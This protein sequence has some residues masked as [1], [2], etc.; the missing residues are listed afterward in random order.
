ME[1]RNGSFDMIKQAGIERIALIDIGSN[2][3]RLVIFNVDSNSYYSVSEIQNIKVSARLVQYVEDGR[4]SEKGINILT[5]LVDKYL[6]IISQY[7]VDRLIAVATA[8]VRNSKNVE[9]II[10]HVYDQ[11]GLE[12]RVL[13][14]EE[15][16]FYGNYAVRY[17]FN[18]YDGISVDIGGGST[19]VT[20]FKGKKIINSH[21]F[22]FGAVSLT[23]EFFSGKKHSDPTAIKETTKWVKKQFQK[24]DWL[25]R[26]NV[27]IV[28]IGGSARN[29][30]E[31]YQLQTDYPIAGTH[32]Y[33]MEPV[34]VEETLELF[35][36]KDYEDLD[37]LDGLSQDRKD[38]I[39]P[40][41][42]VFQQLLAVANSPKFILSRRGLR[43]GIVIHHLNEEHNDPYD[44]YAVPQQ[45][46]IRLTAQYN[47]QERST[48][49]RITIADMLLVQLEENNILKP[50]IEHLEL[51]YYGATLYNL[52]S[53]IEN[54][55]SSQHTYYVISNTN[56]HGFDHYDRVRLALLASYK[57]RSLYQQ[58]IENLEGWFSVEEQDLLLKL[59]SIIKFAEALND[60]H[61]NMIEEIKLT[62]SKK[63]GYDLLVKYIGEIVSEKYQAEKQRNHFERVLGDKVNITFQIADKK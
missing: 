30:A 34:W 18:I 5:D 59:G 3:V 45:Q 17:T 42:I 61:V 62:K 2:T 43:E 48:N 52:G 53:F 10:S 6:Q 23:R 37:S 27:P 29:I 7:D 46:V 44:L 38:T 9:Y 15:E 22:P 28:A 57:N 63:R 60:S 32:G 20:L 1:K 4:M 31:V 12:V 11:T 26:A 21:S 56:I 50:D 54:D 25:A 40:A 16:A 33:P 47:I 39:I 41:A 36:E 24:V 13:S 58:Y 51:M 14:D 49:Q 19:E 55:S 35:T 8:A